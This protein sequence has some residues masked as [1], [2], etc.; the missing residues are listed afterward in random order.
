M[1]ASMT[2]GST[3]VSPAAIRFAN[4]IRQI[5]AALTGDGRSFTATYHVAHT[6]YL[7]V[8]KAA[9][10]SGIPASSPCRNVF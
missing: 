3:T 2:A 10:N 6:T 5:H 9:E 8:Q 1:A 7:Q 4:E